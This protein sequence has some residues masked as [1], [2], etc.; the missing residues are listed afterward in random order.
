MA[1]LAF[2]LIQ[3]NVLLSVENQLPAE[4]LGATLLAS[5]SGT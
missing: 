3:L 1:G 5:A 4:M 2:G